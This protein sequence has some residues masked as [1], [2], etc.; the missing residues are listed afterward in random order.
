MPTLLY[1]LTERVH[2]HFKP[3]DVFIGHPY[4]PYRKGGYGV[5]EMAIGERVRPKVL[6]LITPLHCDISVV[7]PHINKD[8]LMSVDKMMPKVDLLFAIMGEYW[9]DRWDSSLFAHWKPKMV[10]LDM[11]VDT[12][13][14]PFIKDQF[15]KPGHRGYLYIGT[16]SDPR[17]GTDFLSA[18]MSKL[19]DY[20]KAWI[21]DGPEIKNVQRLS[22]GCSLDPVFMRKVARDYD[23]FISP[24]LADP[25]PTTIIES[26]SWGF[27]VVCTPQSGYYESD[28]IKNIHLDDLEASAQIL[29]SLQHCDDTALTCL[30]RKGR[31]VVE[32]KYNWDIFTGS[33]IKNLQAVPRSR[34]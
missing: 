32:R 29:E 14:Y 31:E 19:K 25:N 9:W 18:L 1:H 8:F 4:F 24:S 28:C 13:H 3:D 30:G 12:E 16:S 5:T 22:T 10:R 27:P 20:P 7:T 34:S 17:K 33:V 11:A 15:N 26:L 2:C 6:A 21:G 23:F